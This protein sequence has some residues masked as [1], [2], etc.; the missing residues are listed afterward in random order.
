[1]ILYRCFAWHENAKPDEADGPLW[2]PRIFQGDGRH[3]NPDFYGCLYVSEEPASSVLEQLLRFR[4]QR[5]SPALLRRRGLPLALAELHLSDEAM[6]LDLDN[7]VML[8]R[9][10]LRP[11]MVATRRRS[12]TQEQARTIYERDRRIAGLKWWSTYESLW[13]NVTVFD[14]AAPRLR[15]VSVRALTI[16]HPVVAE[17]ADLLGLRR[18]TRS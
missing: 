12:L 15:V 10:R 11:S 2:F 6:L 16:D 13:A 7:P 1:V 18:V 14:R 9:E 8:G 5:L 17:T 4:T 3:D